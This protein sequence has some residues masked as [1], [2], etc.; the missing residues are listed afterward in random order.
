[1]DNP[2]TWFDLGAAD[3]E[4][5]KTFYGELFGWGL[6]PTTPRYARVDTRG[7]TG[8]NGGIGRSG[9]GDP[10]VAFYV[11]TEDPGALLR[12]AESMGAQVVVPVT[13]IPATTFAMFND[14][15]GLLIG[16]MAPFRPEAGVSRPSAGGG[17]A[18]DWFE[19]LGS[20]AERTQS[21]YRDLFGWRIAQ[22][23]GAYGLVEAE[24]GGLGGGIGAAG[25]G[26]RWATLYAAVED[27]EQ[28]LARAEELG[29]ARVYG[30]NDVGDDMRT[31]C[32]RDPAGNVFG[33]YQRELR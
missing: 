23:S 4:Q 16:L 9:T 10:W 30:P 22:G 19:V 6:L 13:E 5:L 17:A 1:M 3:D 32:L 25:E 33:V 20:D 21:F 12:R 24:S 14:P 7:G 26:M 18:V 29:G 27:V 28:R 31:G 8:I 15:D 2:V 11:E